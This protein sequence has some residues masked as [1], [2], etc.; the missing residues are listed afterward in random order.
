M[1]PSCKTKFLSYRQAEVTEAS[2]EKEEVSSL[3]K[4]DGSGSFQFSS[5]KI[6]REEKSTPGGCRVWKLGSMVNGSMGYISPI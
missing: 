1:D 6:S 5:L 2:A 3:R 4:M